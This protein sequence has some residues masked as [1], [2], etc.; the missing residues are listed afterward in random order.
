VIGTHV[1][2]QGSK[3]L[4][5]VIRFFKCLNNFSNGGVG[6]FVINEW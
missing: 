3:Y 2:G 5:K 6:S 1:A 4:S